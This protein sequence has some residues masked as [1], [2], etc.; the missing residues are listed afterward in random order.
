MVDKEKIDINRILYKIYFT[1][2]YANPQLNLD[3]AFQLFIVH[4]G[5]IKIMASN[6]SIIGSNQLVLAIH[7]EFF[8]HM[9]F[10]EFLSMIRSINFHTCASSDYYKAFSTLVERNNYIDWKGLETDGFANYEAQNKKILDE[11]EHIRQLV[12]IFN[13]YIQNS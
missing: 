2:F 4:F 8:N 13:Q 12:T 3:N 5:S 11:F 1:L 6:V 7:K 9:S 10:T